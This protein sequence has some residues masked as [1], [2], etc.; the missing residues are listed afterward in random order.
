[1]LQVR[2]HRL[3]SRRVSLDAADVSIV[4]TFVSPPVCLSPIARLT[5]SSPQFVSPSAKCEELLSM[6]SEAEGEVV[7]NRFLVLPPS[8]VLLPA[9][10]LPTV[11]D[12]SPLD[13]A[14]AYSYESRLLLDGSII[15][16]AES[17]VEA[18]DAHS[19]GSDAEAQLVDGRKALRV[20]AADK[21]KRQRRC[22]ASKKRS[23]M[24]ARPSRAAD[25]FFASAC[26]SR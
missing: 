4:R 25:S 18:E 21:R 20:D 13:L 6:L 1:M 11:A 26:A 7:G 14:V 8:R 3:R 12:G 17:F 5:L 2:C 23:T 24:C 19:A 16:N 9:D 15:V 10:P 22:C